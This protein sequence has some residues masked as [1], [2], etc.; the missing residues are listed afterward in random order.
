M[1]INIKYRISAMHYGGY[2]NGTIDPKKGNKYSVTARKGMMKTI[3]ELQ[4]VD[5]LDAE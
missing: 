5:I 4:R 2:C 1:D 3:L